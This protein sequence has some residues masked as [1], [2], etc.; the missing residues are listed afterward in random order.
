MPRAA[1]SR[2]LIR[3][4]TYTRLRTGFWA[5]R[6]VRKW[7][8]ITNPTESIH[9]YKKLQ[10]SRVRSPCFFARVTEFTSNYKISVLGGKA[11]SLGL[12]LCR[13]RWDVSVCLLVVRLEALNVKTHGPHSAPTVFHPAIRVIAPNRRFL[14]CTRRVWMPRS[15]STNATCQRKRSRGSEAGVVREAKRDAVY[16]REG[17]GAVWRRKLF[18]MLSMPLPK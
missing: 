1:E 6:I 5:K 7:K 18:G 12:G 2:S 17:V 4:Q 16:L 10:K 8:I 13:R 3:P 11:R 14:I 15:C 9:T